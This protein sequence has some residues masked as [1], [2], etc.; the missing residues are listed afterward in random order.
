MVFS[1]TAQLYRAV[2]ASL[3]D[4]FLDDLDDLEREEEAAADVAPSGGSAESKVYDSDEDAPI[5]DA[6]AEYFSA[7]GS[8]GSSYSAM[9]TDP[10]MNGLVERVKA[11][12]LESAVDPGELSLIEDCNK[13]VLEIDNEI[14]N[15]YNYVRD[16]YSKRFPKLESIVYSPLDYISVVKRAQNEMDFTKVVLSDLLPN[17]M[18][19]AVT[20]AATTSSGSVLSSNV[21][22]E[23]LIACNDG[24]LLAEFRNDILV[25]LESRMTLLA[26]NV[27]AI[28][29]SALA[30]RLITQAGGLTTLAKMPSQ[31]IML[32]GGSR[33]GVVVPGVIHSCEIIQNAEPS[34]RN[35]A[36]KLVS[37]KLS[38]AAKIDMFKESKDGSM[39]VHY[40]NMIIQALQK[41]QEPP[42]APTKKSLP[43]PDERK[44]TKRGGRR[45]RK[46]KE[47]LATSEFRKYANRL[48]F[49][50]EAEDE[51]GLESG[52]GLGMIGKYT[53]YGRL[54]LQH[55][56]TKVQ[57][58]KK[59]QVAMQSS[60][61][62]NGMSSSLVFTPLQGR[63]TF[64]T[65]KRAA[66]IE[67][68]N[69]DAAKPAVKKQNSILDN[70]SGFFK[71][72]KR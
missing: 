31:N 48:K 70:T 26:P 62:T 36:V 59:R 17:T 41:A 56:Q 24:L 10:V 12:T 32:V 35:R 2:Q 19:M 55:K 69:P 5:I 50:E 28:I 29:G 58:P 68:C 33:K 37:G 44:S 8:A 14:I 22:K 45:L 38:L 9:V 63:P 25:Y 47:R 49:G 23:V 34:T 3:V 54:R 27:S 52:S 53:G 42:P 6:V 72:G 71:V 39:G 30:A 11:L 21:L 7:E 40:R 57:L 67:L 46:A 43:V 60:G 66:G 64:V 13:A 51:Y 15:I 18:I 4:S 61:A 20:V 1:N 65:N 16:I